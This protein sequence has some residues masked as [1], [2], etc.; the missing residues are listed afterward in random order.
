MLQIKLTDYL[1]AHVWEMVD[2]SPL[3]REENCSTE[4]KEGHSYSYRVSEC[5]AFEFG[6][7]NDGSFVYDMIEFESEKAPISKDISFDIMGLKYGLKMEDVEA[8][9]TELKLEYSI[10]D[11]KKW[12]GFPQLRSGIRTFHFNEEWDG[13]LISIG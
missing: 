9:L 13:A 3:I 6:V 5:A 1:S 2:L 10:V 7:Y 12:R 11:K 4:T 8:F